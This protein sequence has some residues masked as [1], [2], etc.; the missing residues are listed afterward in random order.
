MSSAPRG[1]KLTSSSELE[2]ERLTTAMH[3]PIVAIAA[4]AP[5]SAR[6]PTIA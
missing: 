5:P 1:W 6:S 2:N 3:P 4:S